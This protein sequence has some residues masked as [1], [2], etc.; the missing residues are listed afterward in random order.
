[1]G[2]N[3]LAGI[4]DEQ[5]ALAGG[6]GAAD[7]VAEIDVAWGVDEIEHVFFAVLLIIHLDGV[8]LDGDS[9]FSFEIHV[10][11]DLRLHIL[12]LDGFCVLEEAVGESALAVVDV[13]Y[14]AEIP[15]IF[16]LN[17]WSKETIRIAKSANRAKLVKKGERRGSVG[18]IGGENKLLYL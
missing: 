13:G 5:S 6:D 15:N 4:D 12:R 17:K 16:H 7:L 1:M 10:V 2:L 11:E 3:P 18:L 9:S 8:A 14:D